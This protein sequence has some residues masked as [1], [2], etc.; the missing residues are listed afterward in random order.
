MSRGE[1][2]DQLLTLLTAGHET[3]ATTLAWTIER[4]R[5]HPDLL[6]RL[7]A[8]GDAGGGEL[9]EATLTEV[10]RV[11]P[12]VELTSRQVRAESLRI[13]R[14]TLPP[15]TAVAPCIALLHDDPEL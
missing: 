2:A 14:W 15:G 13:G 1:I 4:V 10:Q 7:V 12:V 11:R 3:T 5:R 9:R 8:E 6:R